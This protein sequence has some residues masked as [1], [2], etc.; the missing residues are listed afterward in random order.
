MTKFSR[1]LAIAASLLGLA[2]CATADEAPVD[3]T[4]ESDAPVDG[5]LDGTSIVDKG[6]LEWLEAGANGS[7]SAHANATLSAEA[8]AVA[9]TFDLS[10]SATISLELGKARSNGRAI[11]TVMYVYE[12]NTSGSWGRYIERNDDISRR[13][14]FSALRD[15]ELRQG[16]YRV[17]VKG[18][19]RAET[20]SFA[21]NATCA[22]E[23]CL[24]TPAS[25]DF[26]MQFNA[27]AAK[28]NY[29]SES[30]YSP[31]YVSSDGV[32][33]DLSLGTVRR[34][35]S[36]EIAQFF[37]SETEGSTREQNLAF[38][39]YEDSNNTAR[40]FIESCGLGEST[41]AVAAWQRIE[42]LMTE[43]LTDLHMFK[44]GPAGEHGEL[45]SD[46]GLCVYIIVGK[47]SAGIMRGFFVGAVET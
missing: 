30:D 42:R 40:D 24:G 43:D 8:R 34:E 16:T 5:K 35:L 4:E 17:V 9:W 25:S 31:I 18:Y 27:V 10:D 28:A 47:D 11:D 41:E 19:S 26:E 12:R 13:N 21:I 36:L 2:G 3:K 6:A 39:G 32:V 22:G 1:P 15:M 29:T 37:A 45:P 33:R 44:A 14:S 7:Y 23:G 46:A 20:G 38:E